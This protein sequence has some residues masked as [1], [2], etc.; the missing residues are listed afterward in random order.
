MTITSQPVTIFEGP[1]GGGKTTAAK[2]FAGLTGAHYV[3]LGPLPRVDRGLSRIYVEAM[4]PA[5]LG[6]QPVVLDRSWLSEVPYG[7]VYRE[8]RLRTDAI[9]IRLLER[10]AWRCGAVVV[11]CLPSIETCIGNFLSRQSDEYLD[12]TEQLRKIHQL[13]A[14]MR[15]SLCV[16][17]YDYTQLGYGQWAK[18]LINDVNSIRPPQ[19][20]LSVRSA[21]NLKAKYVLVGESFGPVKDSDPLY[22]W[23]FASFSCSGCSRWLAA[24]LEAAGVDED[25]LLWVNADQPLEDLKYWLVERSRDTKLIPLGGSAFARV[26]DFVHNIDRGVQVKLMH[27]PQWWKRFKSNERYPLVDLLSENTNDNSV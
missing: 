16:V 23:P 7:T 2:A 6:Y 5:L 27:H 15:T 18:Q 21:G 24:Q 20:P 8:G 10:L 3:H 1:D 14:D 11:R 22:Q 13:Y 26:S 19:H 25:R 4:L 9:D 12:T 17:D